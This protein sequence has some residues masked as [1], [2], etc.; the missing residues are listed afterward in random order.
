MRTRPK[1]EADD[2]SLEGGLT[3]VEDNELRRL[4]WMAERGLAT[5]AMH[6]RINELRQRD[7]R[8][9]IRRPRIVADE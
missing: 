2:A 9:T 3:R 8:T 7:R 6:G 1:A 5:P 4:N